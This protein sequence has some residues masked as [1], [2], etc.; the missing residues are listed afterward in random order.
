MMTSTASNSEDT[1][2]LTDSVLLPR[3]AAERKRGTETSE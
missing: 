1:S 2:G 3:D